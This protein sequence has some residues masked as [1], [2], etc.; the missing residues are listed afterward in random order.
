MSF[1][2]EI[3]GLVPKPKAAGARRSSEAEIEI[4]PRAYASENHC[5]WLDAMKRFMA[6][7]QVQEIY[8]REVN[9]AAQALQ[10]A[11]PKI[12]GYHGSY[13][14]P[15]TLEKF[16]PE[17]V[18]SSEFES[19]LAKLKYGKHDYA[20]IKDATRK[21]LGNAADVLESK[22]DRIT[23]GMPDGEG[24]KALESVWSAMA[25]MKER[26]GANAGLYKSTRRLEKSE[27]EGWLNFSGELL[28]AQH[29]HSDPKSEVTQLL[30]A[31]SL[32][33]MRSGLTEAAQALTESHGFAR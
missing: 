19:M 4:G 11:L 16:F 29:Y 28:N 12:Y 9:Q 21:Y 26:V 10:E 31:I 33:A 14:Y 5:A 24:S 30:H 25:S 17:C 2:R 27:K 32:A 23:D 13:E 8:N 7:A 18:S 6:D 15:A 22:L 3:V 20:A 1:L